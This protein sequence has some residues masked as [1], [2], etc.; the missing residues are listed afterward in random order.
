MTLKKKVAMFENMVEL[1]FYNACPAD[2]L[3]TDLH[4]LGFGRTSEAGNAMA[5]SDLSPE[6]NTVLVVD[7]TSKEKE[8][9]VCVGRLFVFGVAANK[10]E[11]FV[12]VLRFDSSL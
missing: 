11:T 3:C 7:L 5:P 2:R 1:G 8:A 10:K 6:P 4:M 9:D 12:S